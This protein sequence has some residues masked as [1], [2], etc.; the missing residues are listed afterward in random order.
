ML[1]AWRGRSGDGGGSVGAGSSTHKSLL[2]R[3]GGS[4]IVS[5]SVL[6]FPSNDSGLVERAEEESS[7]PGHHTLV[8]FYPVI[9]PLPPSTQTASPP[10]IP[11]PSSLHLNCPCFTTSPYSHNQTR[12]LIHTKLNGVSE[13]LR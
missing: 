9:P 7:V 4:S 2:W 8:L 13:V 12:S 5:L 6:H 1:G 10:S 3:R 11:H